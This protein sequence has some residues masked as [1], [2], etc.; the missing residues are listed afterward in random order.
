[1]AWAAGRPGSWV[2]V[3]LYLFSSFMGNAQ[4]DSVERVRF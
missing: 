1:M 2:M 3:R 4:R